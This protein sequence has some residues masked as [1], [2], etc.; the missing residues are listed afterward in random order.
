[1]DCYDKAETLSRLEIERLQLARL[2][3][4]LTQAAKSPFYKERFRDCGVDP[5]SIKSLEDV[6]RLPFT[7]KQDLRASYPDKLLSM[8]SSPATP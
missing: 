6:K 3:E 5:A 7:T 8:S 1:M 4:T 2:R